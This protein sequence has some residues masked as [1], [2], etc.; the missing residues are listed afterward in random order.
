M[1]LGAI[2]KFVGGIIISEFIEQKLKNTFG[3][4]DNDSYSWTSG[5]YNK[6]GDWEETC[7]DD[8]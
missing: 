4:D 2:L 6:H 7:N 5:D 3:D 1:M 8:D